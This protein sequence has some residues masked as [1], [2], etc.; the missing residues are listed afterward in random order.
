MQRRLP[1][2]WEEQSGVQ[3]TF[4]HKD[5]DWADD[6]DEAI[7][8][9]RQIAEQISFREKVL[10]VAQDTE[11]AKYALKNCQPS[12]LILVSLPTNDTWARDHAAITIEENDNPK[13]LDFVFNGWGMKFAADQD[14]QITRRLHQNKVFGN[15][16]LEHTG[17]VLEGGSIE[18]DGKGTIL[19][20][21]ECLMSFNRNYP[22]TST[23]IEEKIK[24]YFGA[25]RVLWLHFGS[26]LGDDTDAH[27]DTLARFC[28][29]RTIAY[30]KC[31]D[32]NDE[33]YEGLEKME[34]E[35][36]KFRTIDDEPYR[37]VPLPLPSPMYDEK[38][39]RLPSTYA[40]FLII[41]EA[42]LV[43]IYHTKEDELALKKL[44]ECFPDREIVAIDC[45]V[46]VKQHGS[47]HC[48]T[49]QFPRGVL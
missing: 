8:C 47:L 36:K 9:F 29:E 15:L 4:P 25:K 23:E 42:V 30:V 19:T 31:Y 34:E 17:F 22:L 28:D 37:L 2:E 45:R 12:N 20:T 5:T 46:L 7:D 24:S 10:V 43:P 1:A 6:L 38:G 13:L 18:S 44:K 21:S 11:T 41:N 3:L 27:I 48:V 35:L 14:N 16:P 33:H 32:K 26:L 40:N 49:M 39:Y